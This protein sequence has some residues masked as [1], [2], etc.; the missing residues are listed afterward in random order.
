MVPELLGLFVGK[1]SF[2]CFAFGLMPSA[3]VEYQGKGEPWQLLVAS[4][5]LKAI[6]QHSKLR[7]PTRI[8]AEWLSEK[9]CISSE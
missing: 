3:H 9:C 6:V 4:I 5:I 8:S 7:T 1:N 2:Y